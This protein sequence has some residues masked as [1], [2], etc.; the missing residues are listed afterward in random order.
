MYGVWGMG[1]GVWGMGYGVGCTL[2]QDAVEQV[3]VTVRL[4][5]RFMGFGL[6]IMDRAS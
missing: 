2:V 3:E 4:R 1:Y 6:R 5:F